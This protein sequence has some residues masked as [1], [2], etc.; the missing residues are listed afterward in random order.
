MNMELLFLQIFPRIDFFKFSIILERKNC[1]LCYVFPNLQ[2]L[3]R[4]ASVTLRLKIIYY[5]KMD[6]NYNRNILNT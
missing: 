6:V 2:F 5:F 1:S 4:T 3:H